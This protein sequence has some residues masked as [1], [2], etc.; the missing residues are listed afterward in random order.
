M[1]QDWDFYFCRVD[2]VPASIY[3]DLGRAREGP[4]PAH[5]LMGYVRV[6]M[7]H[8]REDGLS[9]QE[10]FDTLVA[11]EDDLAAHLARAADAIFV[12]RNTSAG[13]SDHFFY[14]AD[15]AR[16]EAAAEAALALYPAYRGETGV[17][18]DPDWSTYYKFLSPSE[19]DLQ[20][21]FNRRV[22]SALTEGGDAL[23]DIRPIDH[24]AYFPTWLAAQTFAAR[25]AAQGFRAH[26][27]DPSDNG[28]HGVELA[29]PG[30]P[31][32]IDEI[33]LPLARAVREAGGDYDGWGCE[34][35]L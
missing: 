2:D 27:A 25:M 10:E 18:S 1:S 5:P 21:I 26:V 20:R 11:I 17:Q 13:N 8:P 16:F 29:R 7:L 12:G 32:E 24:F 35:I 28:S 9:S 33:V 22:M 14:C 23:T 34:A 3:L 6:P 19:D 31:S 4:S 15:A 30:R